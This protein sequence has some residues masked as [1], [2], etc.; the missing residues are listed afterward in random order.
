MIWSFAFLEK[1]KL[2]SK[3]PLIDK[4]ANIKIFSEVISWTNL[5][6]LGIYSKL[7]KSTK[8]LIPLSKSLRLKKLKNKKEE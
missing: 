3:R 1:R 5:A 7:N 2:T 8:A 6:N 4:N